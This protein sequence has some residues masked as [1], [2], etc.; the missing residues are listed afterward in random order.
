MT[1]VRAYV[2]NGVGMGFDY[3]SAAW[4]FQLNSWGQC[5]QGTT[6]AAALVDLQRRLDAPDEIAVIERVQ[7]DEQV[8]ARDRLPCT[9]VERRATLSILA[10]VRPKTIAL[11]RSC[12]EYELDWDDPERVLPHYAGW[13]TLRQMGW[14]IADTESRYY[15]PSVGLA[16]REPAASLFE[17]LDIS[18][19]GVRAAVETLPAD[20]IV[21]GEAGIWTTV[22]ILRR[23][24]WHERDELTVMRAMRAKAR[25]R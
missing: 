2:E 6:E 12:S 14:H 1:L 25:G 4:S 19:E 21:A 22:K 20:R 18:A 7:G 24:A 11:L 17:E 16:Y 15:L 8:F 9:A 10:E 5:G 23:L 13:R 3:G